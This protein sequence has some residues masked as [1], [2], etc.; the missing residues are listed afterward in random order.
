MRRYIQ[1]TIICLLGIMVCISVDA[2]PLPPGT[3]ST[4]FTL[5]AGLTGGGDKLATVT[6]TDGSTKSIYAGN[7]IFGDMGFL[8][9]FGAS[10]WSFKGTLGYAYTA[11]VAKNATIS[12]S[13]FP[14]DAIAVYSYGR[15]HF[16]AG[17]TYYL[18]PKLDMDGFAPNV[19]FDNSLGWLI[20][21]RYWLFGIRY[22]NI[23][24]RSSQGNVNGSNLGLFFN[25]TF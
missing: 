14:L 24:Y 20:E 9:D 3:S 21:Y 5:D 13:R 6:F 4:H 12:F 1:S 23:T 15:N 10:N 11:I 25:Y 8:T 17:L 2:D 22:T 19:D 16:G 7:A 18:N